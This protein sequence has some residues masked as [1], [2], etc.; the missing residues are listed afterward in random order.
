[1]KNIKKVFDTVK[2]LIKVSI[3]G[4]YYDKHVRIKMNL[5]DYLPLEKTLDMHNAAIRIR[6]VFYGSNKCY[7]QVFFKE[8]VTAMELP[9]VKALKR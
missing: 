4:V 3:S 8:K 1:M 6:F 7:L 5:D 2:Y 9:R